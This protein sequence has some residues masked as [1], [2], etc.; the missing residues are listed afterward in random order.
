[1][2]KLYKSIAKKDTQDIPIQNTFATPRKGTL[3]PWTSRMKHWRIGN[4]LLFHEER[5]PRSLIMNLLKYV[6]F[7]SRV[8]MEDHRSNEGVIL[9]IL[10]S[11][12]DGTTTI[13]LNKQYGLP[14]KLI[15]D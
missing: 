15:P 14:D 9:E 5:H 4:N 13:L 3:L 6:A 12:N 11:Y 8:V 7:G 10:E 1:V 2:E